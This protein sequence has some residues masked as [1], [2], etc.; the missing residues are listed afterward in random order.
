M[1]KARTR[2]D[3]SRSNQRRP[4]LHRRRD[5]RADHAFAI[6]VVGNQPFFIPPT[7]RT[8][9]PTSCKHDLGE[10]MESNVPL[11]TRRALQYRNAERFKAAAGST[12]SLS[13]VEGE[14]VEKEKRFCSV[15]LTILSEL[16]SIWEEAR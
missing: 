7:F 11:T 14:G 3:T 12:N 5:G 10:L 15:W 6:K 13:F 8:R 4:L 2:A 16:K 9:S 1:R